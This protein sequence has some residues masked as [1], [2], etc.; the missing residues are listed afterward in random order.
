MNLNFLPITPIILIW[1]IF[2]IALSIT[3]YLYLRKINDD[4]RTILTL[5]FIR[6]FTIILLLILLLG[7]T[8]SFL[9]KHIEKK[10]LIVIVDKSPSMSYKNVSEGL[11]SK[12]RMEIAN[13]VVKDISEKAKKYGIETVIVGSDGFLVE[14]ASLNKASIKANTQQIRPLY[15]EVVDILSYYYLR[16]ASFIFITDCGLSLNDFEY[17]QK[18]PN[19]L[20]ILPVGESPYDDISLTQLS[21]PDPVLSSVEQIARVYGFYY[22]DKPA[23]FSVR[24]FQGKDLLSEVPQKMS[25]G[26]FFEIDIPFRAKSWADVF[27]AQVVYNKDTVSDDNSVIT[28]TNVIPRKMRILL[29]SSQPSPDYALVK[30]SLERDEALNVSTYCSTPVGEI[31]RE[32]TTFDISGGGSLSEY[33]AIVI[34]GDPKGFGDFYNSIDNLCREGGVGLVYFASNGTKIDLPSCPLSISGSEEDI[35]LRWSDVRNINPYFINDLKGFD[36][37]STLGSS[38]TLLK[39]WA[40]GFLYDNKG[41]VRL[42]GGRYSLGESYAIAFWGLWRL[43]YEVRGEKLES[44]ISSIVRISAYTHLQGRPNIEISK[45]ESSLGE[46]VEFIVHSRENAPVR[47]SIYRIYEGGEEVVSGGEMSVDDFGYRTTFIP[48]KEGGYRIEASSG[49]ETNSEYFICKGNLDTDPGSNLSIVKTLFGDKRVLDKEDV[50]LLISKLS[51]KSKYINEEF[52]TISLTTSPWLYII[53]VFFLISDWYIRKRRG[54][55]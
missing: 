28:A 24:L 50:D 37:M 45:K 20:Y 14:P 13:D 49:G 3:V 23:S 33:D 5:F 48:D 22:G 9:S 27:S 55:P 10:P 38:K 11:S 32:E 15:S 35:K 34:I 7:L 6:S 36:G 21:L 2:L 19:D 40:Y 29:V 53:I 30:R 42:A 52:N 26:G 1:S 25:S 54:L 17:F 41:F 18:L 12:T 31:V 16:E 47:Y 43:P 4:R 8:V 46:S 39:S 51:G 44:L